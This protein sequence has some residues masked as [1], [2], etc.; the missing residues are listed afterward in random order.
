MRLRY[1]CVSLGSTVGSMLSI[2]I[3]KS[4]MVTPNADEPRF[5]FTSHPPERGRSETSDPSCSGACCCCCCCCLHTLGGLIGALTYSL[6][7]TAQHKALNQEEL[8]FDDDSNEMEALSGGQ[9]KFGSNSGISVNAIYW[10]SLLALTVCGLVLGL[11]LGMQNNNGAALNNSLIGTA[12]VIVMVLPGV[13]FLALG[14]SLLVVAHGG[15]RGEYQAKARQLGRITLGTTIGTVVGLC[16]MGLG[17]LGLS[18][19]R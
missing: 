8:D 13:Q 12:C 6:N 3:R 19:I 5:Q 7:A 16:I 11:L 4:E 1:R 10:L 2:L 17:C 9:K 15:G 14:V 18:V